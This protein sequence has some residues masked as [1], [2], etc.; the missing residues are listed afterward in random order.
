MASARAAQKDAFSTEV[1]I[2]SLLQERGPQMPDV[3]CS[4]PEIGSLQAL[5]DVD[6]LSRSGAVAFEPMARGE[7]RVSLL[8]MG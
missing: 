2:R 5:P 8:G 7:Y 4:L 3:L 6:R 1:V